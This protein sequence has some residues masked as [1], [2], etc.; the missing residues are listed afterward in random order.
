[1]K[2]FNTELLNTFAGR[3][4]REA[5]VNRKLALHQIDQ[6]RNYGT[7][8]MKREAQIAYIKACDQVSRA[9]T[10]MTI[11]FDWPPESA[12]AVGFKWTPTARAT[13]PRGTGRPPASGR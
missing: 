2:R 11:A 12:V 5:W 4:L 3:R 6:M 9:I 8:T 7:P 1:M 10:E 13:R